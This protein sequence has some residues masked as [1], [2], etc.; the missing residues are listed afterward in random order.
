MSKTVTFFLTFVLSVSGILAMNTYEK[1]HNLIDLEHS[2]SNALPVSFQN[3]KDRYIAKPAIFAEQQKNRQSTDIQRIHLEKHEKVVETDSCSVEDSLALV[4]IYNNMNGENWSNQ[5]NWLTDTPVKEWWGITVDNHRVTEIDFYISNIESQNLGGPLAEE[6]WDLSSL[7]VLSMGNNNIEGEIPPGIGNLTNLIRLNLSKNSLTGEIPPD[8]GD[9]TSLSRLY[10]HE[11]SFSGE[12]PSEIGNLTNLLSLNVSN[13]SLGGQLPSELGNLTKMNYLYLNH[14]AFTG[15]IPPEIG[16]LTS[17]VFLYLHV[18]SL[19]KEIPPEMGNMTSLSR[20]FIGGNSIS[21][22]IPKELGNLTNLSIL[23]ASGNSFTGEIPAQFGQLTN[24]SML[25]LSS[26]SLSGEIPSE[27][28]NLVNLERLTLFNN[29]LE[30]LPDFSGLTDL[31]SC[32]VQDNFL[33]FEDLEYSGID[34]NGLTNYDYAPQRMQPKPDTSSAGD[35]VTLIVDDETNNN[36]YIWLKDGVPFDTTANNS[37]TITLGSPAGYG[38]KIKNDN[39][40]DLTLETQK[41]VMGIDNYRVTFHVTDGSEP[42]EDAEININAYN[43]VTDA[44]GEATID[45][46][47]ETYN[48]TVTKSRYDAA[49]GTLTVDGSDVTEEVVLTETRYTVTFR[50]TD[51]EGSSVASATIGLDGRS[52]TTDAN[53]EAALDTVSGN[54]DYTVSKEGYA[55]TAGTFAVEGADVYESTILQTLYKVTFSVTDEGDSPVESAII[56]VEGEALTTD[57]NGQATLDTVN[58][59]YDYTI[60][61]TGYNDYT[62]TFTVDDS[63]LTEEIV[64]AETFY[65]VTFS[66]TDKEDSPVESATID[67]DGESLTTG[68]D[69]EASVELVN[70]DYE[71][72][73]SAEGYDDAEG[74]V[75]VDGADV[76]EELSLT[77]VATNIENPEGVNVIVYPVP[78]SESVVLE[79]NSVI[80]LLKLVNLEGMVLKTIEPSSTRV[81]IDMQEYAA[82]YY[83]LHIKDDNGRITIKQILIE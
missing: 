3:E 63:D 11:N 6:L 22:E 57:A 13:N 10:L 24:L 64:L 55:N 17:V 38:C 34:W 9:I 77:T 71:Y 7:E 75:E 33:T 83:M 53:G 26:N 16:N 54:Y 18:N 50:V 66:V 51:E 43:L 5:D 8:I 81:S 70:G 61:K 30:T 36:E 29:Y 76:I 52:L 56:D 20:L 80:E 73:V 59:D 42:V 35:D 39:Y 27:L 25:E 60:M 40:P 58:G 28:E 1:T 31:S 74:N 65:T 49:D 12:I 68:S 82:G 46:P 37:I 67:I 23:S 41:F 79:S 44:Q 21:G 45:L 62:A 32:Y 15:D 14:N 72:T 69:G 19:T 4:A 47:N 2:M 78:A 48:Y